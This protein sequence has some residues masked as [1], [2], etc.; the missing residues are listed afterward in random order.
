MSLLSIAFK[1]IRQRA[2]AS[3]LT[4]LSVAL[5]VMLMVA[6]LVIYGIV[7]DIFGQ[8]SV[9]YDLIVGPAGSD[10]Q[11]VLSSIYRVSPPIENLPYLYFLQLQKDKRIAEAVPLAFGDVTEQGAFP[12]VGTVSRYF[13]LEYAPN[14]KFRNMGRGMGKPFDALIGAEVARKNGWGLGTR[15]K[16]VHGGIESGH[17][18]DEEFEVVGILERT[19]TPNDKTAFVNLEGFYMVEG[20]DKP[21]E[22]ALEQLKEFFPKDERIQNL[23][24]ADIA[25]EH[26]HHDHDGH[27]HGHEHHSHGVPDELKEVTAVLL[28]MSGKDYGDRAFRSVMFSNELKQGSKKVMAVNPI[29]PITRL[30]TDVVGN[31]RTA[32]VVMTGLI[33]IVS[34]IGIFVSIYN[35]MA[36]RRREIAIMRALG[37]RRMTVFAIIVAE[38]FLLC[39][40]GGL[41]GL[42]LGHG[43]VFVSA[44]IVEA[45]SGLLVDPLAFEPLEL[46]LF[47]A[48][49][50]LAVLIGF[51]PA[52]TAYRTDVARAL[53]E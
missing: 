47:P 30:M 13:E 27:D 29:V 31:V 32:L 3:S 46:I 43:L 41:L 10:L 36:D 44:P 45:R 26:D 24:A 16:L 18:H 49:I 4:G 52:M 7:G 20:H 2:L 1:S 42:A 12:I 9:G 25:A 40:G 35:S 17:V 6:V 19:G 5:G 28:I 15:F 22:E 50:G 53:A 51:I 23:T 11:L 34:G 8:N 37:A 21:P 38:A 33:I 14:R 48:L 39:V